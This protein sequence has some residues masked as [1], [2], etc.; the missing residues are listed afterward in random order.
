MEFFG[1][2]DEGYD[3]D[4]MF[5]VYIQEIIY[6]ADYDFYD[7]FSYIIPAAHP[8]KCQEFVYYRVCLEV[9]HYRNNVPLFFVLVYVVPVIVMVFCYGSIIHRYT[10]KCF[11]PGN[12]IALY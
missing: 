2:Q 1:N 5:L 9:E 7:T 8:S 3:S 12:N 11:C 6:V 10:Y 4:I